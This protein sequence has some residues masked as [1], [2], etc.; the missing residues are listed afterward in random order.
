MAKIR[1]PR[2]FSDHF[3]VSARTLVREGV[4]DPTLNIDTRLFIDP[5]LLRQSRHEEISKGA[6]STYEQHFTKVIKFLR[7]TKGP[8]GVAVRTAATFLSRDQVDLSR[9]LERP[10]PFHLSQVLCSKLMAFPEA[11]YLVIEAL[12]ESAQCRW[13]VAVEDGG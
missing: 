13:R 9:H 3:G 7:A 6:R 5:M 12:D 4:L 2:R 11:L 10:Y 8:G 1:D